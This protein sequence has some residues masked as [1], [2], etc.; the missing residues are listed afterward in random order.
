[1]AHH[2]AARYD[3]RVVT[4]CLQQPPG[5][6]DGGNTGDAG[7]THHQWFRGNTDTTGYPDGRRPRQP[8]TIVARCQIVN[9]ALRRTDDK[10]RT[11]VAHIDC[12]VGN[13]G[14]RTLAYQRLK[15]R[16]AVHHQH[17]P[18]G[19]AE[20]GG[21]VVILLPARSTSIALQ[22]RAPIK[23]GATVLRC[24]KTKRREDIICYSEH[25]TL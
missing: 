19:L 2:I 15:P 10:Q 18:L 23:Q 13:G 22:R 21:T 5:S 20:S 3:G 9:V 8:L 25:H 16:Q 1:M 6:H 7:I 17:V 14:L 12:A 4:A 11:F 24:G